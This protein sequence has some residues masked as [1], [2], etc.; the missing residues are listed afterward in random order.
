MIYIYIYIYIHTHLSISLS[1]YIYIY[2][3]T[4][5]YTYI[6]IYIY[7]HT[8]TY[9]H[10]YIHTYAALYNNY[11]SRFVR[12]VLAQETLSFS[13]PFQVS[14]MIPEGNPGPSLDITA[15]CLRPSRKARTRVAR[16]PGPRTSRTPLCTEEHITLD[17]TI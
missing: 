13:V 6:Y 5:T 10:T 2:I 17:H 4:H 14:R 3:Y 9:I 1:L 11:I 7:I 8:H 16:V 12:V 15:S